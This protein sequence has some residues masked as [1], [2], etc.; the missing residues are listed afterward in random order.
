[1]EEEHRQQSMQN[2]RRF[3]IALIGLIPVGAAGGLGR[4][5]G[6]AMSVVTCLCVVFAAFLA[7]L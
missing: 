4:S 7:F 3:V 5:R 2:T 1:M 6:V